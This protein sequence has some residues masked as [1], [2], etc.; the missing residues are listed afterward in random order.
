MVVV[1]VGPSTVVVVDTPPTVVVAVT[2]LTVW[3]ALVAVGVELEVTVLVVVASV[4]LE[5]AA[6]P[7]EDS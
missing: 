5:T 3:D 1:L 7:A 4:W 6:G 2:E